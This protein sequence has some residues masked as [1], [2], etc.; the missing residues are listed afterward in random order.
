MVNEKLIDD[1]KLFIS[2]KT[3]GKNGNGSIKQ[4]FGSSYLV[5]KGEVYSENNNRC[6]LLHKSKTF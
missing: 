2:N 6:F 5:L 1:F 4:Y 3:L